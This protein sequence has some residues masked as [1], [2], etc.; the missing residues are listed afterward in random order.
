MRF[1]SLL[2]RLSSCRTKQKH[3]MSRQGVLC[4]EHHKVGL[5]INYASEQAHAQH[6]TNC[7]TL[8]SQANSS[9]SILFHFMFKLCA[10]AF[11]VPDRPPLTSRSERMTCQCCSGA[12][13]CPCPFITS[14]VAT[15]TCHTS[16]LAQQ[17]AV[18]SSLQLLSQLLLAQLMLFRHSLPRQAYLLRSP[19]RS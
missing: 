15:A 12:P 4:F 19:R 14:A 2:C 11:S 10:H 9:C 18:R 16:N 7:T 3:T 13:G 6:F 8:L 5:Y 17:C 1:C